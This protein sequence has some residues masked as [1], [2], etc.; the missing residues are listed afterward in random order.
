MKYIRTED[1]KVMEILPYDMP[2]FTPAETD[3]DDRDLG[4]LYYIGGEVVWEAEISV[5]TNNEDRVTRWSIPKIQ[6]D[7]E[8]NVDRE[9]FDLINKTGGHKFKLEDGQLIYD[10]NL[11]TLEEIPVKSELDILRDAVEM[12]ILERLGQNV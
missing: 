11:L 2:G 10:E 4:F 7:T 1:T 3:Y 12:L 9:T 8:F 6:G 5:A